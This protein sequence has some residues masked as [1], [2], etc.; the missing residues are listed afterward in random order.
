[1][2]KRGGKRQKQ[3]EEDKEKQVSKQDVASLLGEVFFNFKNF[4]GEFY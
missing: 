1:M 3:K 2:D 4:G